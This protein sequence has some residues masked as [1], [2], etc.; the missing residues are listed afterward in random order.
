MELIRKGLETLNKGVVLVSC[1]FMSAVV[2]IIGANVVTRSLGFPIPGSYD[3]AT[4]A[5][6]V[7]GSLAIAY[8]TFMDGHVSV[9]IITS[10]LKGK[11]KRVF[12][13][14]NHICIFAIFSLVTWQSA[15]TLAE[16]FHK[17]FTETFSIPFWPFRL[18]W[19]FA[20]VVAS[21]TALFRA[22]DA[23]V[24]GKDK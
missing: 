13:F 3:L 17:E 9:D 8:T 15:D 10:A 4:L 14:V 5:A 20:M 6:A 2:L 12:A 1:V 16:R 19:L 21:L 11:A 24:G 7:T 22:V 23:L 18:V